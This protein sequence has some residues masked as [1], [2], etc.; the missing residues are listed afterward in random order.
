MKRF[1]P[2][3]H[4]KTQTQ[5][6]E[7]VELLI[8]NGAGGVFL[9]HHTQRYPVSR[10]I[11]SQVRDRYPDL[12]LGINL[13]DLSAPEALSLLTEPGTK[14]LD[15][16][17][18]DDSGVTDRRVSPKAQATWSIKRSQQWPGEYFGSVAFKA[19]PLVDDPF[20]AAKNAR[21]L[22]DVVVT[23]GVATGEAADL[24]KVK[25][26]REAL[27]DH[28]LALASGVTPEN[29]TS[30]LPYVDDFLVATGI[31]RTFHT[32]DPSRVRLLANLI[33]NYENP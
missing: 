22:M 25:S 18:S 9:I 11:F 7:Q 14:R 29:V 19:G 16:L 28:R 31:S 21:G 4:I 3:L 24:D 5:T 8:D 12:W 10:E 30:Y 15:A 27:P 20:T 32:F 1:L 26:M 17:W 23:S 33:Q 13:L 6:L 2:V